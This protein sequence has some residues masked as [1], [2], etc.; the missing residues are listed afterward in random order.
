MKQNI[1][2]KCDIQFEDAADNNKICCFL[3]GRPCHYA[4]RGNYEQCG[5]Y[6]LHLMLQKEASAGFV[7]KQKD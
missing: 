6:R 7:H 5:N 3:D 1:E 4:K 2:K